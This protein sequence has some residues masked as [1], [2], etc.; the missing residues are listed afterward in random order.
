MREHISFLYMYKTM[1]IPVINSRHPDTV[2]IG[3]NTSFDDPS[4]LK[5]DSKN[6][7]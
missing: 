3:N 6:Y 4:S 1:P 5:K 2:N 7:Q